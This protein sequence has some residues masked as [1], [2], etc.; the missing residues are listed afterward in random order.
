LE[1]FS[2]QGIPATWSCRAPANRSFLPIIT[3]R[4]GHELALDFRGAWGR[5]GGANPLIDELPH[6]LKQASATGVAISTLVLPAVGDNWQALAGQG[7]TAVYRPGAEGQGRGAPRRG[8][9]FGSR[10][11]RSNLFRRLRTGLWEVPAALGMSGMGGLFRG[12]QAA[13]RSALEQAA[14]D[15][16]V[17]HLALEVQEIQCRGRSALKAIGRTLQYAAALRSRGQLEIGT[18]S[19]AVARLEQHCAY[20]PAV[21][22]LRRQAA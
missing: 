5:A 7:I 1:L 6:Q 17:L 16:S 9:L 12:E 20:R 3:T 15:G 2:Q 21:S 10:R 22:I 8:R 14:A 11:P 13:V 18:I 4:Q 19:D